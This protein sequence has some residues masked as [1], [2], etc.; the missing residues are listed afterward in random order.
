MTKVFGSKPVANNTHPPAKEEANRKIDVMDQFRNP[1]LQATLD[2]L[3]LE[4]QSIE[5]PKEDTETDTVQIAHLPKKDNKYT[6]ADHKL[7]EPKPTKVTLK[8]SDETKLTQPGKT[9][10]KQAQLSVKV[11]EH[12]EPKKISERAQRAERRRQERDLKFESEEQETKSPKSISSK[13]HNFPI[14]SPKK[15]QPKSRSRGD[16]SL[17]QSKE[18][19]LKPEKAS[20]PL[21]DNPELK[22][23]KE[24]QPSNSQ[25][26]TKPLNPAYQP[27][28]TKPK[29][30]KRQIAL[31]D[32]EDW[33]DVP[34]DLPKARRPV[35]HKDTEHAMID[36]TPTFPKFV[37][38]FDG[39]V[40][41]MDPYMPI[42]LFYWNPCS[43]NSGDEEKSAK[44]KN[45]ISEHNPHIIMLDEPFC[46]LRIPGY[47][48]VPGLPLEGKS[49]LYTHVLFRKGIAIEIILVDIDLIIIKQSIEHPRDSIYYFCLYLSHTESRQNTCLDLIL[50]WMD[51]L[52]QGANPLFVLVGD[53]NINLQKLEPYSKDPRIKKLNQLLK[54]YS[55]VSAPDM[56]FYDITR[57][58]EKRIAAKS[59]PRLAAPTTTPNQNVPAPSTEPLHKIVRE[60][61]RIDWLLST[62]TDLNVKCKYLKESAE[63]SDHYAFLVLVNLL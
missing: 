33:E 30:S 54:N 15:T 18:K 10:S 25:E 6:K 36:Q 56:H 57:T 1:S 45:L 16:D 9:Q 62:R 12:Q 38:S 39:E 46:E 19:V 59:P 34:D 43:V 27:K 13:N 61:S 24:N 7:K 17:K 3:S 32:E 49:K 4:N 53:F 2:D 42:K 44:K 20:K 28:P 55:L 11:D 47:I 37:G 8:I 14:V 29:A 5:K 51:K 31:S 48:S 60:Q 52:R 50:K 40:V 26:K 35:D 23:K 63:L 41:P 58:R 21:H 22:A